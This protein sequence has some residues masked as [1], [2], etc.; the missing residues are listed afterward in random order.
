MEGTSGAAERASFREDAREAALRYARERVRGGPVIRHGV[1][2]VFSVPQARLR[3]CPAVLR[4]MG[5][6]VPAPF[7]EKLPPRAIE[8]EGAGHGESRR[9]A[10]DQGSATGLATIVGDL[11]KQLPAIA[12]N[13]AAGVARR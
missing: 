1:V 12:A 4:D 2:G 11:R 7:G 8:A 5:C 9:R 10:P 13:H 6:P 3:A